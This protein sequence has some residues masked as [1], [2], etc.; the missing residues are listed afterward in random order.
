MKKNGFVTSALL[1]GILSLFLVLVLGTIS[2]LANRKLDNDKIKE[3]A[4]DDVQRL[5]TDASYFTYV[6]NSRGNLSITGYNGSELTVFI[7]DTINGIVVDS[8]GAG[9]FLNKN[10]INVTI[11]SNIIEIASDA[12]SGND[13]VV[14][15]I[16]KI[17]GS[18]MGAPWGAN[19]ATVHW[20]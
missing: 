9:A 14:F 20:N 16:K 3:S 2:I 6:Q 13:E 7:P 19:N 5:S 4:L 17:E 1:Y 18:I 8:I 12:F 11:R 10:L 15:F